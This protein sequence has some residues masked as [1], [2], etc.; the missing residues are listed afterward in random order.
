MCFNMETL[1]F[2]ELDGFRQWFWLHHDMETASSS[3]LGSGFETPKVPQTCDLVCIIMETPSSPR[4]GIVENPTF[5]SC[6]RMWE[7]TV[8]SR[9]GHGKP[10][11]PQTWALLVSVMVRHGNPK[12]PT[13]RHQG[14]TWKPKVCPGLGAT[15]FGHGMMWKPPV[16][17]GLGARA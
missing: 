12:F 15:S 7:P 1:G 6:S 2:L 8:P 17:I 9:A 16:S 3:N 10:K 13:L 5:P 14:M 11:F 4:W